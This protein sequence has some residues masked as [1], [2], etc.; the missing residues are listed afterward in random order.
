MPPALKNLPPLPNNIGKPERPI[1]DVHGRPRKMRIEDEV[2][3]LCLRAMQ[4][5]RCIFK[6]LRWSKTPGK[7]IL[8]IGLVTTRSA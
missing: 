8:Y 1:K 5:L 4:H 6:S 7:T 2:N 3:L